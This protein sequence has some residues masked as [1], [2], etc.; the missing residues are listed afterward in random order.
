[1]KLANHHLQSLLAVRPLD[2][3]YAGTPTAPDEGAVLVRQLLPGIPE[4]E[5]TQ[6]AE[7]FTRHMAQLARLSLPGTLP[8]REY[9]TAESGPFY[10][11]TDVPVGVTLGELLKAAG[12]LP[13]VTCAS[14]GVA[15]GGLLSHAHE[16][17]VSHLA[18]HRS[19]VLVTPDAE[20]T[21][22]D[23]G[24]VPML[25]ERVHG[26]LRR[27]HTAWDFLFPDPGAVAPELLA[28][29]DPGAA[30]DVYGMGA[31]L[32][33]LSTLVLPYTGTSIVAYNAIL[34]GQDD[35][36]PRSEIADLDPAFAELVAR[37]LRRDP[38]RRPPMKDVIDQLQT[39]AEPLDV[40]LD[41]YRP[42]IVAR[43]YVERFKPLLRVVDG[44]RASE[45]E[46]APPPSPAVVPLFADGASE[47]TE[48]ELLAR[49]NAE[50]RRIYMAGVTA[51]M[52]SDSSTRTQMRRGI[53]A[54]L[55]LAIIAVMFL[56]PTLTATSPQE[57]A[58]GPR[59]P[60]AGPPTETVNL[61][62]RAPEPE[63]PRPLYRRG[64]EPARGF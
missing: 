7:V 4:A 55:V 23:L 8:V 47:L 29:E 36:D 48:G 63:A 37:C 24:I 3:V 57:G 21:L 49:M 45:D 28:G 56:M 32:Y 52:E 41:Q 34:S 58:S 10:F 15:L 42:V 13:V 64:L 30:T 62:R 22:L 54:G 14:I 51:P 9:T 26:R 40:A 2:R 33:L 27:V 44:G 60:I 43:S 11:V 20:M 59:T 35:V 31:L 6:T 25:L 50:Q 19:Q 17:G 53:V 38:S 46:P 61:Q 5:A 39:L 18:L 12:S 1:M 16:N